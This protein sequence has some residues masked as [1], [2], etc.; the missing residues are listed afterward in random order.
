MADRVVRLVDGPGR[1]RWITLPIDPADDS[2]ADVYHYLHQPVPRRRPAE[3]HEYARASRTTYVHV[4]LYIEH[5][6]AA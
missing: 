5:E 4:A 3:I 6:Q 2:T 1:D